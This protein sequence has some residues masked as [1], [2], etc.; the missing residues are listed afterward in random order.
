MQDR[1][2]HFQPPFGEGARQRLLG[3]HALGDVTEHDHAAPD[4]ADLVEQGPRAHPDVHPVRPVPVADEQVLFVHRLA[5][6]DGADQRQILGSH[7]GLPI[8]I[9]GAVLFRPLVLRSVGDAQAD[10]LLGRRIHVQ[11]L[12]LGIGDH[13]AVVDALERGIDEL[14]PIAQL[15]HRQRQ[16]RF[17]LLLAG[18]VAEH[19]DAAAAAVHIRGQGAAVDAD[20]DAVLPLLVAD[21]QLDLV[22]RIALDGAHQ[23]QPFRGHVGLPIGIE[24]P[25][26]LGPLLGRRVQHA[27]A[28]DLLG[29]GIEQREL[30]RAVGDH[31]PVADAA[32]DGGHELRLGVLLED[33]LLR[34]GLRLPQCGDLLSQPGLRRALLALARMPGAGGGDGQVQLPRVERPQHVAERVA[35]RGPLQQLAA[36]A[37]G[38]V[39]H[40]HVEPAAEQLAY[41]YAGDLAVQAEV[42][43]RQV[44]PRV[45]GR[46]HGLSP[47][48]NHAAH[49]V[50]Q[51]VQAL[52]QVRGAALIG[53][54]NQNFHG[55]HRGPATRG[56][57][58][59]SAAT[60]LRAHS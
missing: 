53:V 18:D 47:A 36:G 42:H 58:L 1:L 57:P 40:R 48:R 32:E 6:V 17:R 7:G 11:E 54:D 46:C 35:R 14:V 55:G 43:Q 13:D 10:D 25:V 3:N 29:A 56:R 12:A 41:R 60:I 44:G 28:D 2:H 50:P 21:E 16:L 51:A 45:A 30:A 19:D 5:A 33:R 37:A 20:V 22:G 4:P 59:L 31:H 38:Q 52:G 49:R 8:R 39:D 26:A 9:V 15:R 23:G 24:D 27:D 34:C